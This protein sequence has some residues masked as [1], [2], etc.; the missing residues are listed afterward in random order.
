MD[1][2]GT[3]IHQGNGNLVAQESVLHVG[4][5]P[6]QDVPQMIPIEFIVTEQTDSTPKVGD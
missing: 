4:N 2:R 1:E 6:A 3:I 5:M